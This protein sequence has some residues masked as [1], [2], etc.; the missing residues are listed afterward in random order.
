MDIYPSW[1]EFVRYLG[2]DPVTVWVEY[3]TVFF[4]SLGISV[5]LLLAALYF[6]VAAIRRYLETL[7]L[8]GGDRFAFF[9]ALG[10]I[11]AKWRPYL[12]SVLAGERL[13][14][15]IPA[16]ILE[17]VD[18]FRKAPGYIVLAETKLFFCGKM[19]KAKS[20][21]DLTHVAYALG[22]FRDANIKDGVRG[23][24]LKLVFEEKRPAFKLLGINRELGQEFFMRMHALRLAIKEQQKLG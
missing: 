22:E 10:E 14:Y 13:S 12:E 23:L 11:D 17:D 8:H 7:H 20:L 21:K 3:Q 1:L 18:G 16:M 9:K 24:E 2:L 19:L 5:L 4:L 15:A 6:I